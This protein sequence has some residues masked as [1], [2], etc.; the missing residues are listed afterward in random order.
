MTLHE[1]TLALANSVP[2]WLFNLLLVGLVFFQ[3]CVYGKISLHYGRKFDVSSQDMKKAVKSGMITTIGPALSVFIVGLGLISQIGA[4][5]IMARLSIIGNTAFEASAAQFG[6]AAM[7]TSINAQNYGM[8]AYTCSVWALNLG[9]S[10]M[11]IMPMFLTKSLS[12]VSRKVSSSSNLGKIIGISASLASIGYLALGYV[13]KGNMNMVAVFAAFLSMMSL[14]LIA[15]KYK[16]AW[17]K[18]WALGFS[19]LLSVCIV[20]VMS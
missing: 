18:E 17:L 3:A 4:P 2:S 5:L 19:I 9:A 11:L 1:Q 15:K 12:G 20:L 14:L 13:V 6:A 10:C 7:G 8:A 16:A